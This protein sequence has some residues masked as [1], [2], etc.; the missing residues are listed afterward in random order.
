MEEC[1]VLFQKKATDNT[2]IPLLVTNIG[3][4]NE[5]YEQMNKREE[6]LEEMRKDARIDSNA[7]Y[8]TPELIATLV[9][10]VRKEEEE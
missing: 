2:T 7:L 8:H 10:I 6:A 5:G 9:T 3:S 4:E 1:R